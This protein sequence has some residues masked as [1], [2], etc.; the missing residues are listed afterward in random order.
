MQSLRRLQKKTTAKIIIEAANGPTTPEAN[1]ILFGK[2][3]DI[4]PGILANAGGVIVSYFEWVQNL[5]QF[6]WSYEEIVEQ[7]EKH[8]VKAFWDVADMTDAKDIVF[9]QAAYAV[10]LERLLLLLFSVGFNSGNCLFKLRLW[11]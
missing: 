9:R 6:Y 10:A 3:V 4:I 1:E 7:L 8:L 11:Y 5:Q 2:G